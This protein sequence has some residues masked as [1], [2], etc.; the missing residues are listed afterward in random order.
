MNVNIILDLM[1]IV[2]FFKYVASYKNFLKIN[3]YHILIKFKN[4]YKNIDILYLLIIMYR[5]Q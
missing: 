3:V 4:I 2:K 1:M 5:V